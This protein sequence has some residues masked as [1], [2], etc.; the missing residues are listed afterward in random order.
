MRDAVWKVELVLRARIR[1]ATCWI[2][3]PVRHR[4]VILRRERLA[5]PSQGLEEEVF[6]PAIGLVGGQPLATVG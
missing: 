3:P 2:E 5:C 1:I 4:I 6:D